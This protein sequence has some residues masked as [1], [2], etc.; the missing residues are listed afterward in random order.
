LD[1]G[2]PTTEIVGDY[3]SSLFGF[4]LDLP[5][6]PTRISAT[7]NIQAIPRSDGTLTLNVPS[8]DQW[9]W[10]GKIR[11]RKDFDD[12]GKPLDRPLYSAD[13]DSNRGRIW[14][15]D[16]R[17]EME[18][19]HEDVAILPAKLGDFCLLGWTVDDQGKG[20]PVLLSVGEKAQVSSCV[21]PGAGRSTTDDAMKLGIHQ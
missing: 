2:G 11:G 17:P 21:F 3:D 13:C 10:T 8:L 18:Y 20:R 16:A 4:S 5:L 6:S 1:I 12:D 15:K 9:M 14:V 19:H 7:G